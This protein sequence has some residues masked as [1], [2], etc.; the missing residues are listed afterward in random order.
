M[1]LLIDK[2]WVIPVDGRRDSIENGAVAIDGAR[3]VAVGPRE[4]VV[5]TLIR[6]A[7]SWGH[8]TKD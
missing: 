6:T 8:S 4:E 5:K 1:K 2:G 7:T 3:I